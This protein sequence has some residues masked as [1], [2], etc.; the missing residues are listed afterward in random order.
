MH[1]LAARVGIS[2]IAALAGIGIHK[3]S[4]QMTDE[5]KRPKLVLYHKHLLRDTAQ[6]AALF[7]SMSLF[8]PAPLPVRFVFAVTAMCATSGVV[9]SYNALTSTDLD[10]EEHWQQQEAAMRQFR[11]Q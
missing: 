4:M 8:N 6:V 1:E 10:V 5:S 11:K 2:A 7:G 9:F 3:V